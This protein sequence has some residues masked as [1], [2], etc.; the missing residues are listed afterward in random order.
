MTSGIQKVVVSRWQVAGAGTPC[1]EDHLLTAAT[2]P[3]QEERGCTQLQQS[4]VCP[5]VS[6]LV[7]V[8]VAVFFLG[9]A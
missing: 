8:A 7:A 3:Q 9:A 1:R 6:S 2:K 5:A 4:V